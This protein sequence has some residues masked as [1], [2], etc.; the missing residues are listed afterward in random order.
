MGEIASA[1]QESA[2]IIS[3]EAFLKRRSDARRE[4]EAPSVSPFERHGGPRPLNR[5]QITHRRVML[6]YLRGD[7]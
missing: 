1:G 6:T 4:G 3:F 5:R 2:R 7:R